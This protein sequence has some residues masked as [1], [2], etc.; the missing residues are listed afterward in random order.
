MCIMPLS[1]DPQEDFERWRRGARPPTVVKPRQV[2]HIPGPAYMASALVNGD[3]SGLDEDERPFFTAFRDWLEDEGV[4]V[5]G[6]EGEEHFDR[7][8]FG[9]CTFTGDVVTY[10]CYDR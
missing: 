2:Y 4:V 3:I 6:T 8:A 7:I 9:E 5:V 10:V 1:Y